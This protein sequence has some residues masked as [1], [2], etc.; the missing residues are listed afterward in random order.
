MTI[1]PVGEPVG[2]LQLRAATGTRKDHLR[3]HRARVRDVAFTA[4]IAPQTPPA[5]RLRGRAR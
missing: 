3:H 5:R 4:H 1:I 2:V